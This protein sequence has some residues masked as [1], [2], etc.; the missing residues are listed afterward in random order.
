MLRE[1]ESKSYNYVAVS[2][3][4]VLPVKSVKGKPLGNTHDS[5]QVACDP[6]FEIE[7]GA[8]SGCNENRFVVS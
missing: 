8:K 7:N 1:K 4:P 5:F 3:I 2:S 6:A